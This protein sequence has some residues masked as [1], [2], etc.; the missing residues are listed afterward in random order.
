MKL[1][2]EEEPRC[3]TCCLMCMT[4]PLLWTTG[5]PNT[6]KHP[7]VTMCQPNKQFP[8]LNGPCRL[9]SSGKLWRLEDVIAKLNVKYGSQFV[10]NFFIGIDDRDSSSHIIHVGFRLGSVGE[11]PFCTLGK[12][13]TMHRAIVNLQFVFLQYDQQG[14]LG[15]P[16]RDQFACTGSSEAVR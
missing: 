3:S 8:P 4:G 1:R 5:R 13:Y 15:L 2:R 10:I 12:A 11:R 7:F 14:S 6:V 9:F 16:S